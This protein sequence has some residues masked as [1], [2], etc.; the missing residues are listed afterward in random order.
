MG[1]IRTG[2]NRPAWTCLASVQR[3]C[4]F[5]A[6][7]KRRRFAS[8]FRLIYACLRMLAARLDRKAQRDEVIVHD[9]A[10]IRRQ[11]PDRAI[12]GVRVA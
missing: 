12:D 6:V 8:G 3:P 4:V 11:Q 9:R 2:K 10:R 7:A 1:S 5:S